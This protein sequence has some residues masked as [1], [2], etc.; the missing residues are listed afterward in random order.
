MNQCSRFYLVQKFPCR[1]YYLALV[2]GL[3]RFYQVI[4]RRFRLTPWWRLIALG[5]FSSLSFARR[6]HIRDLILLSDEP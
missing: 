2:T 6:F 1:K 4:L 5:S 3:L